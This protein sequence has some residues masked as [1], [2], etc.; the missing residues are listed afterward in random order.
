MCESVSSDWLVN[1]VGRGRYWA[2]NIFSTHICMRR[3]LDKRWEPGLHLIIVVVGASRGV[4][5]EV[6]Q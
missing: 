2:A 6:R 4:G 1:W 5:L 3:A